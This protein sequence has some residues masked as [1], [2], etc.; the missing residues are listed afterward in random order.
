MMDAVDVPS[1]LG[2]APGA[3]ADA[4][5]GCQRGVWRR[6]APRLAVLLPAAVLAAAIGHAVSYVTHL[7]GAAEKG[8]LAA[9]V[10]AALAFN[11]FG[12]LMALLPR[13]FVAWLGTALVGVLGGALVIDWQVHAASPP[14]GV[15]F[16][17]AA[18]SLALLVLLAVV[19]A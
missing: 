1:G 12:T 2:L 9:I 14:R 11:C 4:A 8:R 19:A 13:V 3:V 16:S 17:C 5:L 18:L 6:Y 10:V 15:V 7:Y